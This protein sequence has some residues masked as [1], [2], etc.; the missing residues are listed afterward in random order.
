MA[1]YPDDAPLPRPGA[2]PS[3]QGAARKSRAR[4]LV[5]MVVALA[6]GVGAAWMINT[7]V[8]QRSDA[9]AKNAL[10]EL[11]VAAM[12][13]PLGTTL[14][15]E[16]IRYVEWPSHALPKGAFA[17]GQELVGRVAAK[18]FSEGEPLVDGRLASS[19]S[20]LGMAAVVPTELRAMTVR[21]NDVIGVAGFVH[22][23]DLVDIIT[24]MRTEIPGAERQDFRSKIVLQ[25]V[26]VLAVGQQM[27]VQ[28][29]KPVK[30]PVVTLL[31]TPA[32]SER[33]AL[34]SSQGK[35]QLTLRSRADAEEV[36]TAGVTPPELF[37]DLEQKRPA[38]VAAR[39]APAPARRYSVSA[40][41]K[42]Q[43]EVVEVL[44]GDR[45][46]ERKVRVKDGQ[47]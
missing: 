19:T 30:V 28:N 13:V 25:N 29:D 24:T 31:V 36:V 6:A 35:I 11:A 7:W 26:K 44:R 45:Y 4:A 34:A 18:D 2:Q 39:P 17:R 41:A 27:V 37:G 14:R 38:A 1:L 43:S 16:M 10:T 23:N 40:P 12:D 20:G 33:L 3:V 15:A 5:F 9:Q 8:I 46:E 32:D 47:P 21:V 42:P 22:P